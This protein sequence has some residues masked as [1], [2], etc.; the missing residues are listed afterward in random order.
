MSYNEDLYTAIDLGSA[1]IRGM[2]GTKK[3]GKVLPIAIAEVPTSNAIRKGVVNNMEE[4]HNKLKVLIDRL[5]EQLPDKH[6][7]IKKVYVGF[8][9]KSLMSRSYKINHKM[10]NPDGEEISDYHINLINERVKNYRLNAH[11]VLDVSDPYCLVDGRVERNIKG[12]LCTEFS[13]HFNL[14][15]TRSSNV[16]FIRMAI[17][18]RL[19]L[20]L[21]AILPSPC[22]EADVL[23]YPDAK[24]LGVA[25][26]NIGA[27]TSSV[28]IYKNDTLKCLRVIPFG[29]KNITNDLMSLHITYPEA[30]KIKLESATPFTDAYDDETLTLSSPDGTRD[31]ELKMRDVNS[32]VTARMKE[33]TANVLRVIHDFEAGAR[34]GSGIV[35]AGQGALMTGFVNYLQGESKF[36][37]LAR[38]FNDKVYKGDTPLSGDVDYAGCAG[39][40]YRA[41]V[42][43]IGSFDA[44]QST[45]VASSKVATP[46]PQATVQASQP[47]EAHEENHSTATPQETIEEQPQQQPQTSLFDLPDIDQ[48]RKATK[49]EHKSA[50]RKKSFNWF[51]KI[52]D[53]LTDDID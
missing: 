27:G 26:V 4:L 6:T 28:A 20:E 21:E 38:E 41:E 51:S 25:L 29:S 5:N 7:E 30:E 50:K 3:D 52:K 42:N 18:D 13:I 44:P 9:G 17:E 23:L 31:R 48:P 35:L 22:C 45:P 43:C 14:I 46:A 1:T 24:T 10:D 49:R 32:L 11:E 33:I 40:I 39:L 15:T 19:G 2:V 37:S 34:L 36:V 16:N 8:G 53:V 47:V 12:L